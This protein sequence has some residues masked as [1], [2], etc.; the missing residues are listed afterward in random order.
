MAGA[1]GEPSGRRVVGR[2]F[3]QAQPA[4]STGIRPFLRVVHVLPHTRKRL[5]AVNENNPRDEALRGLFS[6][7]LAA[8]P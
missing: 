7:S 3:K 6:F 2:S 5:L 8:R 4:E 1:L